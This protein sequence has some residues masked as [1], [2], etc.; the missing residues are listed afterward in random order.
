M[1]QLSTKP[2]SSPN[3]DAAVYH[4]LARY[5]IYLQLREVRWDSA[6]VLLMLI[7]LIKWHAL[8]GM[9]PAKQLRIY[10][11]VY[12]IFMADAKFDGARHAQ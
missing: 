9:A 3:S 6:F 8:G 5:I 11:A 1:C 10:K 2:S 4:S 12:L 7:L